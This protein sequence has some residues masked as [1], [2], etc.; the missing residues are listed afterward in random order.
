MSI[1]AIF[2]IVLALVFIIG[3]PIFG[4]YANRVSRVDNKTET[5][6]ASK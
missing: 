3:G 2:I 1:P 4:S 6:K 5:K